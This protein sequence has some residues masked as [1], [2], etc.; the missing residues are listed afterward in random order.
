[1]PLADIR[2]RIET[3]TAAAGRP[4]GTVTLIAVSKVQPEDRVRAVLDAG[5]RVFGENRVQEASDRWPPFLETFGPLS[6]H[7][8]GP[9]QT[10][11]LARALDLFEA[12]HSLDRDSLAKKLAS[13]VQARGKCPRLFVQVNTGEEAQKAGVAPDGLD[14]FLDRCHGSYDLPVA[15]LMCI[16]PAEDDPAAHFSRL[17]DMA[18]RHGLDGLSMGMSGDFETAIRLGA[19]HVRVG[20]A[21]FGDRASG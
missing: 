4:A 12:I 8:I 21:I 3:A 7:L 15:G 19:T 5:Q 14:A 1:M 11:K 2:A 18:A 6:L 17:R 10:N 16:P 9:L 13:A 20:S